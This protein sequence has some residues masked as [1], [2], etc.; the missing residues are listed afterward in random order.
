MVVYETLANGLVRARSD[1][2]RMIRGGSPEGVYAEAYDPAGAGREYVETDE[3]VPTASG[4]GVRS[5]TPLAI[6]RACGGLWESLK[7]ALQEAGMYEDFI[8]AQELREDDEDFARGVARA[9]EL[10]GDEAV[11]AVLNTAEP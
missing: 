6:K 8:M 4:D 3:Y 5:W 2:G 7:A 10:F 1:A 9:R 11:D